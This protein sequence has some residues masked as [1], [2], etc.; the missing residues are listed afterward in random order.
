MKMPRPH[1]LPTRPAYSPFRAAPPPSDTRSADPSHLEKPCTLG[2]LSVSPRH[3]EHVNM[4]R[5]SSGGAMSVQRLPIGLTSSSAQL[6]SRR[7]VR[8][9]GGMA[10][11]QIQPLRER[12]L[13]WA[14]TGAQFRRVNE[15]CLDEEQAGPIFW[16]ARFD[17]GERSTIELFAE[18]RGEEVVARAHR[19]IYCV[20]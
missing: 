17:G 20:Y 16:T 4:A 8:R 19:M 9:V 15:S 13:D 14:R 1:P 12:A 10:T 18:G 2:R 6:K 3:F 7:F 11:T 5:P